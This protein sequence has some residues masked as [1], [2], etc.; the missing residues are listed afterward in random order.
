MRKDVKKIC[1]QCIAYRQ[2]KYKSIPHDL[3]IPLVIP[4]ER[5]T[6]IFM[7]FVLALS[8]SKK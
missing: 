2:A 7:D 3:Y 4:S 8:K 5:W 1:A 6:N